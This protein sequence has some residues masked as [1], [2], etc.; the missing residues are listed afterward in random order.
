MGKP[1]DLAIISVTP[2]I[3]LPVYLLSLTC[4]LM[5]LSSR[6]GSVTYVPAAFLDMHRAIQ[7]KQDVKASQATVIQ[8]KQEQK[9]DQ[10]TGAQSKQEL[11]LGQATTAQSFHGHKTLDT[12]FTKW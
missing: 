2:S 4:D 10:A 8:S 12:E 9:L 7:S 6:I 11:K 3:L 1:T 5:N